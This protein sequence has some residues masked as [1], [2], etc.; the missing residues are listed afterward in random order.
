MLT[1]CVICLSARGG[2][3]LQTKVPKLTKTAL[4]TGSPCSVTCGKS[5]PALLQMSS[6]S[7]SAVISQRFHLMTS[8]NMNLLGL[9]HSQPNDVCH[10][11]GCCEMKANKCHLRDQMQ[12]SQ[13]WLG[14]TDR[15]AI[16]WEIRFWAEWLLLQVHCQSSGIIGLRLRDSFGVLCYKFVEEWKEFFK[17]NKLIYG[18]NFHVML[19]SFCC[20]TA[21]PSCGRAGS[22]FLPECHQ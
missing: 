17:R 14:Y 13:V 15:S 9:S 18:K 6:I 11:E 20:V 4:T 21:E 3:T 10:S 2:Q 5:P 1:F 22:F 12:V 16:A 7:L 8:W 19:S